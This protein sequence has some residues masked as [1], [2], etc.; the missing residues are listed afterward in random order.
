MIFRKLR[1]AAGS[2]FPKSLFLSAHIIKERMTVKNSE[3][4]RKI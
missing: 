1:L 2:D 3:K 4:F